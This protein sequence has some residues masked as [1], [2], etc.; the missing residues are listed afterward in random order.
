MLYNDV[1]QYFFLSKVKK[2]GWK[3]QKDL[4]EKIFVRTRRLGSDEYNI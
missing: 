1:I 3:N 4:V 2:L